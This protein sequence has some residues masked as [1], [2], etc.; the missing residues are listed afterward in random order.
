MCPLFR[1]L[2]FTFVEAMVL[3]CIKF[4]I[5]QADMFL[6]CLASIKKQMDWTRCPPDKTDICWRIGDN[7]TNCLSD[8]KQMSSLIYWQYVYMRDPDLHGNNISLEGYSIGRIVMLVFSW[9]CMFIV[10]INCMSFYKKVMKYLLIASLC[11]LTVLLIVTVTSPGASVGLVELFILQPNQLLDIEIWSEYAGM[12]VEVLA[13]GR[14][15]HVVHGS[16]LNPKAQS[17]VIAIAMVAASFVQFFLCTLISH[18]AKG[19]IMKQAGMKSLAHYRLPLRAR[20]IFVILPLSLTNVGAPQLWCF[21]YFLFCI[22]ITGTN[23]IIH[24]LVIER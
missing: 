2:G 10:I 20:Y 3:R 12:V 14:A 9:F 4:G 16:F 6:Y 1:G 24:V 15:I 5:Y 11:F 7:C 18:A 19:V 22:F 23:Q 17:N 13:L 8:T 21:L